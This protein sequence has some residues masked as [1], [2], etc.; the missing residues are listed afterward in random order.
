MRGIGEPPEIALGPPAQGLFGSRGLVLERL[1]LGYLVQQIGEVA[2]LGAGNLGPISQI[3][4]NGG[5]GDQCCGH[6]NHEAKLSNP[7]AVP[8]TTTVHRNTL[9]PRPIADLLLPSGTVPDT[10]RIAS[11]HTGPP[12]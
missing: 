8:L 11:T 10:C 5:A 7:H 9:F 1:Q 3:G 6:C 4:T 2:I 12:D